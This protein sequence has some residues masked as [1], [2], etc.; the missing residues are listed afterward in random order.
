MVMRVCHYITVRGQMAYATVVQSKWT[1]IS[2]YPDS[3]QRY[4][5][6][7]GRRLAPFVIPKPEPYIPL[8]EKFGPIGPRLV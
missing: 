3:T 8:L 2:E 6:V 7:Q 5:R 1:R 4:V